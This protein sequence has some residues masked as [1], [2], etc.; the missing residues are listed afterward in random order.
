MVTCCI[1]AEVPGQTGAHRVAAST[2]VQVNYI[3]L[4]FT[5]HSSVLPEVR[6]TL[7]GLC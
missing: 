6:S 5:T 2:F 7:C 1:T 4:K 3:V